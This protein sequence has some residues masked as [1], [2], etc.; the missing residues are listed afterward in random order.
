MGLA[1]PDYPLNAEVHNLRDGYAARV[2]LNLE[3]DRDVFY[4]QV[5]GSLGHPSLHGTADFSGEDFT[6]CG[7]LLRVRPLVNVYRH[8]PVGITH[9]S[10]CRHRHRKVQ[11]L[12]AN[13]VEIS[14]FYMKRKKPCAVIL[15]RVLLYTR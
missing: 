10:R 4:P 9:L 12:E 15:S 5:I 1:L 11:G 2:S 13:A 8:G 7:S 14:F 6:Q 3:G